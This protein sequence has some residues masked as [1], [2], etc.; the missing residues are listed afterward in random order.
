MPIPLISQFY[1]AV[2][3]FNCLSRAILL[4]VSASI[5]VFTIMLPSLLP[6]PKAF[7]PHCL[8]H[9]FTR[10][11]RDLHN[12]GHR[13]LL[14]FVVCFTLLE[15]TII[16]VFFL[17]SWGFSSNVLQLLVWQI[18]PRSDQWTWMS[19][20]ATILAFTVNVIGS[21]I[22]WVCLWGCFQRGLRKSGRPTL[23][24]DST[25]P[26]AGSQTE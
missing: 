17:A 4:S 13:V 18:F 7:P 20:I 3:C 11:P 12:Q 5:S 16:L 2:K 24:A 6:S 21:G 14:S 26:W 1:C 19:K 22:T 23:N 25:G 8:G 9:R 10:W 15:M